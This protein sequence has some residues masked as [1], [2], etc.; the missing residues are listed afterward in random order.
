MFIKLLY[1]G[2]EMFSQFSLYGLVSGSF[3]GF[4]HD[5]C[6]FCE[7]TFRCIMLC[8]SSKLL[9]CVQK[10]HNS[11]PLSGR[12]ILNS[13]K[14]TALVSGSFCFQT[15][16]IDIEQCVFN[17]FVC[18]L[19]NN[20]QCSFMSGR[21][22]LNSSP[23]RFFIVYIRYIYIYIYHGIY[24]SLVLFSKYVFYTSSHLFH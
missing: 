19:S 3:V 9:L 7:K 2:R 12:D 13:L 22:I 8:I 10:P 6:T 15:T 1:I 18:V 11:L 17:T 21:D 20:S 14:D 5:F 16:F 24:I 4:M 23:I